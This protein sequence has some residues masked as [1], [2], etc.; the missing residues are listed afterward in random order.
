M[1]NSE[2]RPVAIGTAAALLL[3]A[4]CRAGL[5]AP[6][7]AAPGTY[8][9]EIE[10]DVDRT[11]LVHLPA[12]YDPARPMPLVVAIHGAFET[13]GQFESLTGLSQAA[14]EDG[15]VVAYPEGRGIL[16]WVQHWN[17]GFCCAKAK[18]ERWDDVG[19]LERLVAELTSR[20]A[21]DPSRVAVV[22]FS[23]GGMLAYRFAAERRELIRAL[24]VSGA[25]IGGQEEGEVA[26]AS[27]QPAARP[28]PVLVM[29]GKLDG[30]I[31]YAGGRSPRHSDITYLG[32]LEA[33]AR[34]ARANGCSEPVLD[35][36][37]DGVTI[38]RWNGC[39]P[40]AEVTFVSV[41]KLGHWWPRDGARGEPS[42]FDGTEELRRFLRRAF[43]RPELPVK[44]PATGDE[45]R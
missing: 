34:F 10:F 43:D 45:Q 39:A 25:A 8:R 42:G 21:I 6:G 16:G 18:H 30:S 32:P 40:G 19:F 13:A 28:L 1:P 9:H 14:D 20:L 11:A 17:A 27:V 36:R 41:E 22:G 26:M 3:L 15:F 37:A 4:A 12:G 33:T 2:S 23:N 7:A 5:P 31:P 38:A 44:L 35:S 24:A 29:H